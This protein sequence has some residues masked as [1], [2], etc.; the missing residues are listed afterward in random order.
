MRARSATL[1]VAALRVAHYAWHIPL[2]IR[3]KEATC[4]SVSCACATRVFA[5]WCCALSVCVLWCM[6]SIFARGV[7][8]RV[9]VPR[10]RPAKNRTPTLRVDTTPPRGDHIH[11]HTTSLPS[12]DLPGWEVHWGSRGSTA[13]RSLCKPLL[14]L[15]DLELRRSEKLRGYPPGWNNYRQQ[16]PQ[17]TCCKSFLLAAPRNSENAARTAKI[18]NHV[19]IGKNVQSRA[20]RRQNT[21]NEGRGNGKDNTAALPGRPRKPAREQGARAPTRPRGPRG[22]ATTTRGRTNPEKPQQGEKRTT[23]RRAT[24]REPRRRYALGTAAQLCCK[25]SLPC[26][27]K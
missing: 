8:A 2:G 9:G 22:T 24:G 12:T 16:M 5:R 17:T 26:L 4:T 6:W 21:R 1:R 14:C 13:L 20:P 18:R 15:L 25:Q 10:P 3:A 19:E 11:Q 23:S 27:S 7:S